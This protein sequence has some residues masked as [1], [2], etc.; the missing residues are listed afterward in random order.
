MEPKELIF[1]GIVVLLFI[2]IYVKETK[3]LEY[4]SIDPKER[5]EKWNKC[6]ED[7]TEKYPKHNQEDIRYNCCDMYARDGD[8]D[9]DYEFP[10]PED[11]EKN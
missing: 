8:C 5:W 7:Y 2:I 3:M 9:N 1:I 4:Y 11:E 10:E 6:V